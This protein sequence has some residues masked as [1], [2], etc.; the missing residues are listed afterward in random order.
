MA[1]DA[2]LV[3]EMR[4]DAAREDFSLLGPV[5]ISARGDLAVTLRQDAQVRIYDVSGARLATFGRRGS[6]PGE[7]Q[8]FQVGGWVADTVWVNDY[9]LRRLTF[10]TRTGQLVRTEPMGP[11]MP[12]SFMPHARQSNGAMLGMSGSTIVQVAPTGA[13][14]ALGTAPTYPEWEDGYAPGPIA[15]FA[16]DG[17]AVVVVRVNR[18][19]PTGGT[20]TITRIAADG[21][22]ISTVTA[23]YRGVERSRASYDSAAARRTGI[24]LERRVDPRRV[25]P[26]Y[27]PVEA[28]QLGP[29]GTVGVT[30]RESATSRVVRLYTPSAVAIATFALP[31]NAELAAVTATRAWLKEPDADGLTSLVRYRIDVG[32]G[33]R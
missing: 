22:V 1:P 23:P 9:A 33:R 4:L 8:Q 3:A 13:V 11:S 14:R 27:V 16:A 31:P 17:Q 29:D 25:P 12:R 18:L 5:R 28:A 19:V 20:F 15:L 32:R 10:L 24:D 7:F 26:I 21:R 2:R 30:L 6:G